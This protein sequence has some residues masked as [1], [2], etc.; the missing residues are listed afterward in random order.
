MTG[1]Y[2]TLRAVGVDGGQKGHDQSKG[3]ALLCSD[4]A[5]IRNERDGPEGSEKSWIFDPILDI[6]WIEKEISLNNPLYLNF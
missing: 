1:A 6:I 5:V 2:T 3:E 4:L